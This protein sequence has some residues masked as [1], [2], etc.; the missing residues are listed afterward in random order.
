MASRRSASLLAVAVFLEVFPPGPWEEDEEHEAMQ[1]ECSKAWMGTSGKERCGGERR[2]DSLKIEEETP[3]DRRT[4]LCI[5][6][7]IGGVHSDEPS[8]TKSSEG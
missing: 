3:M 5:M 4:I 8:S 2:G 1:Q 6:T 7:C